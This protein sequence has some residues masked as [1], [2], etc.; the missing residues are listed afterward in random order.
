MRSDEIRREALS[1][2]SHA[3]VRD[4][5]DADLMMAGFTDGAEWADAHPAVPRPTA[6]EVSALEAVRGWTQS[7]GPGVRVLRV[8]LG[9]AERAVNQGGNDDE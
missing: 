5:Y 8:L 6:E 1:L 7:S 9:M 4:R 3:N 2:Y